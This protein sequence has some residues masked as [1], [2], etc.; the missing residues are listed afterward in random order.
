MDVKIKIFISLVNVNLHLYFCDMEEK[1]KQAVADSGYQ[2]KF[3]VKK[4]GTT[5]TQFSLWMHGKRGLPQATKDKLIEFL[6]FKEE[7]NG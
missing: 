2:R 6:N 3:L 7:E 1:L 5:E 4:L